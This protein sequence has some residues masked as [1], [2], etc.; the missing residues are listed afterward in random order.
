MRR[1]SANAWA[2]SRRWCAR[3]R[4]GCAG[5][6]APASAQQRGDARG[7]VA[8]R[9]EARIV[10]VEER[11]AVSTDAA[12]AS[13]ER[14]QVDVLAAS[15]SHVAHGLAQ[16]PQAHDVVQEPHAP[17]DAAL[18]R[19][20]RLARLVGDHGS[21]R[22]RRRRAPTCRTR[23]TPRVRCACGTATT[24][25][26]V[27]CEPTAMTATCGRR[28]DRCGVAGEQRA[29]A[30]AGLDERRQDAARQ[31]ERGDRARGPTRRVRTSSRPVVDAFVR[32]AAPAPVSQECDEV[33]DEQRDVGELEDSRAAR[34]RT[35][36][37]C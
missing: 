19:E 5:T 13:S 2:S 1:A 3:T 12:S 4:H 31:S 20:V 10:G 27:S 21:R 26:A 17:V 37:A 32:S 34:R 8:R 23:C 29:E 36:T 11:D 24:A 25:E 28:T 6:A 15:R 35:G 33:G 18:V 14:R 7:H 22:A 30:F 16:Q 9:G